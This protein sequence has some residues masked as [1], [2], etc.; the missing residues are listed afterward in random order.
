MKSPKGFQL[1]VNIVITFVI[2]AVL[3]ALLISIASGVFSEGENQIM[4][5]AGLNCL[6][7]LVCL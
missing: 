5:L 6:K 4:G 1:S 7:L 3:I 2:G